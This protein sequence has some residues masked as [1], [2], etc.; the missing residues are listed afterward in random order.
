MLNEDEVVVINYA[1][2]ESIVI[3]A[4]PYAYNLLGTTGTIIVTTIIIACI[5]GHLLVEIIELMANST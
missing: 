4:H 2:E 5:S 1:T 3:N